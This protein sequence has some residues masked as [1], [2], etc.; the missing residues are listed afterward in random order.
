MTIPIV[1]ADPEDILRTASDLEWP[2]IIRIL[3]EGE[4][5]GKLYIKDGILCFEGDMDQA[6]ESF[7]NVLKRMVEEYIESELRE[8]RSK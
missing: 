6:A 2:N 1:Y 5:V 3:G 8:G 7:F 4:E